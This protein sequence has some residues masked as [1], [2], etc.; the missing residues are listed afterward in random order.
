MLGLVLENSFS[1]EGRH[2]MLRI[3]I[4]KNMVAEA[5]VVSGQVWSGGLKRKL[6]PL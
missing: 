6:G 3:E 2:F 5:G 4:F 1:A